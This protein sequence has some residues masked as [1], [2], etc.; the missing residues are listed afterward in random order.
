MPAAAIVWQCNIGETIADFRQDVLNATDRNK[1]VSFSFDG[2]QFQ[3][4]SGDTVASALLGSDQWL[5]SRSFK[6]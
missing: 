6:Y 5:M 2:R 3:G 1:P 4:F